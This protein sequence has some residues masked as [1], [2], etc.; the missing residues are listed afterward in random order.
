MVVYRKATKQDLPRIKEIARRVI[1]TNYALFLGVEVTEIFIESGMS[2]KELE[3]GLVACTVAE[4]SGQII[5]FAITKEALLHLIMVDVPFQKQGFGA[6]LLAHMEGQ[7]FARFD[8]LQLQ[9]FEGNTAAVQFYKK[10]G[11][12]IFEEQDVPELGQAM[13]LFEKV[14]V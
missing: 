4:K 12:N 9:T 2:D 13:L 5:G 3:D 1:R 7:L 10:H 8:R 6:G 11:W 14:S